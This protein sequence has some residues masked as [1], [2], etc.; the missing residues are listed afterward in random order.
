MLISRPSKGRRKRQTVLLLYWLVPIFLF[1]LFSYFSGKKL[2]FGWPR[3]RTAMCEIRRSHGTCNR[4]PPRGRFLGSC[5]HATSTGLCPCSPGSLEGCLLLQRPTGLRIPG[6]LL[7]LNPW[8]SD[9]EQCNLLN[10]PS[11]NVVS[12]SL[13]SSSAPACAKGPIFS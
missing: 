10:V 6:F 3:G 12:S 8:L 2:A 11:L 1:F 9:W 7:A 4:L 5:P 13:S